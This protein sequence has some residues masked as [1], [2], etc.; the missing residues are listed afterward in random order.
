MPAN[1]VIS[2]ASPSLI[3]QPNGD[4]EGAVRNGGYS[5]PIPSFQLESHFNDEPRKLRVAVIGAG[6]AG[7]T[8]GVLLPV[9]VSSIE[10]V[11]YEKNN[12]VVCSPA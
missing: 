3:D 10:L 1:H 5:Y 11:I 12:D 9:K 7:V 4:I 8:A 2:E 6:L